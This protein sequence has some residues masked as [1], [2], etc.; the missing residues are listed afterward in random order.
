MNTKENIEALMDGQCYTVPE[1]DYGKAEV[2][3]KNEMY[4][5]FSIPEFGG[6]PSFEDAYRKCAIDEMILVVENFL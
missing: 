2:W 5:L 4:F 6:M 3:L 1:S